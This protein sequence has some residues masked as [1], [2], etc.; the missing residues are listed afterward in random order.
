MFHCQCSVTELATST[1]L[2]L[3]SLADVCGI[4]SVI[5]GK[6]D[7]LPFLKPAVIR[8]RPIFNF[9]VVTTGQNSAVLFWHKGNYEPRDAIQKICS[10]LLSK[11]ACNGAVLFFNEKPF[12]LF[13]KSSKEDLSV[14]SDP[15]QKTVS[16][17]GRVAFRL[18]V[19]IWT[20]CGKSPILA[21]WKDRPHDWTFFFRNIFQIPICLGS[22]CLR[23]CVGKD[24]KISL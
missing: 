21:C 19:P 24:K 22:Y 3:R 16:A 17:V 6:D 23:P 9:L 5:A 13:I 10:W 7:Y 12:L 15:P 11:H 14:I 20:W 2:P 18:R 1:H 8:L 4:Q